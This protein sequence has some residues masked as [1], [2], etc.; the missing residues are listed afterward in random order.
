[1]PPRSKSSVRKLAQSLLCQSPGFNAPHADFAHL[2]PAGW[3]ARH[4][5]LC[6][7]PANLNANLH[8]MR[9]NGPARLLVS[10]KWLLRRAPRLFYP[11]SLS[12][13]SLT[14]TPFRRAALQS[15]ANRIFT[16]LARYLE[17]WLAGEGN[18]IRLCRAVRHGGSSCRLL[19]EVL[20]PLI[21]FRL[22]VIC[23]AHSCAP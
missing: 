8:A 7:T 10:G 22:G 3:R 9:R 2:R 14:R 16:T 15:P 4:A 13:Q 1:M 11:A 17:P 12:C 5:A 19:A 18:W 6:A 20:S 21:C 23:S